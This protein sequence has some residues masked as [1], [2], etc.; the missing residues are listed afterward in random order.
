MITRLQRLAAGLSAAAALWTAPAA[1]AQ[2]VVRIISGFPPG[3]GVDVVA[4]LLADQLNKQGGATYVVENKTGAGG[5][6]AVQSMLTAP[7]DGTALLVAPDSN[8][9]IYPHTVASPGFDA[10]KDLAPIT[11]LATYDLAF[12]VRGADAQIKDFTSFISA[13]KQDAK[14]ATFAS[15]AAG[16]LQHF[17]GLS[18]GKAAG[19]ELLHVA[20]RGV[21]PAVTDAIGGIVGSLVTPVGPV[22]QHHEAGAL[23]ILATSGAQRGHK[24]PNVPTFKELGYPQLIARGWF[25]LFAPS[26]TPPQTLQR[27]ARM[28]ETAMK[29]PDFQTKLTALDMDAHWVPAAEFKAQVEAEN[30][31]WATAVQEAGFRADK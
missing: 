31:K 24:T 27:I 11:T 16:S 12:S 4:R 22:I 10:I 19:L 25:G 28:V 29:N 26:Q 8:V 9:V 3:G 21:A 14:R 30:R 13:A 6:I 2:P 20:Y 23:K 7:A 5:A 15:P 17:Y 18:V 1:G